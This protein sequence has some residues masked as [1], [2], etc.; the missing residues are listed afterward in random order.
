MGGSEAYFERLANFHRDSGDIVTTWSTTAIDLEAFWKKDKNHVQ[1][2]I[3]ETQ[4]LY[5]PNIFPLRRYLLK[6]AS[7]IPIPK[8][9][10]ATLPCN[11]ICPAMWRDAGRYDGPLDAVHATAFP[12]A[13][14]ILCGLRLA[15]RRGVP[16]FLTPFLHLGDPNDRANATR[17]QYTSR[18]LRWLLRQADRV[19]VQ[20]KMERDAVADI[21]VPQEKIVLQ[22]L[23]VDPK[24][25]TGGDR[26]NWRKSFGIADDEVVIG[27]LAN[28]SVEKGTVDLLKATEL[29][30]GKVILFRIVLAGPEMTNFQHFW[31]SFN[32]KEKVIRLG[33][34]SETQKRD[35]FAGIDAFALPSLSDS[36]GLVLLEAWANAKPNLVYCAG[37]PAEL[38]RHQ[39]DGVIAKNF[40]E[41]FLGLAQLVMDRDF[42]NR[43][44]QEGLKR[45]QSEFR[46]PEK[47]SLVRDTMLKLLPSSPAS[48]AR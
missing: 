30:W 46:W 2:T 45:I 12:Y 8:W 21:G 38:I 26:E 35:F 33:V 42:R 31:E 6:A 43:L 40:V 20:T 34:L 41:L 28:N 4:R 22:G 13:F 23:G 32:A 1:P 37:G 10:A 7:L 14:P 16:F 3:T 44:G 27:H 48:S 47:L 17:R 15:Q 25:C 18:P 39:R 29:A 19:F 36:F 5:Q 11:P 9:Q 24:E